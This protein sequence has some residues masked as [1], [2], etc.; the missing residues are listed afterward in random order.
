MI[1]PSFSINYRELYQQSPLF[2][3][4]KLIGVYQE[5]RNKSFT[6]RIFKTHLSVVRK[7][8]RRFEREG[9]EGLRDRSR[10]PKHSPRKTPIHIEA[11]IL[12]ER[13]KTGYGRDR[14][15]RN[16]TARGIPVKPST[17]RYVLR[18]YQVSAKY[19]RSRY[20]KKQRFYDF[21]EL[22]PL[23]HFE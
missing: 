1:D 10:R 17:V 16:L 7:I 20:R 15:A 19:K 4:K 8:I 12:A 13:K 9:E 5:T 22:Y 21:E 11:I 14:I 6:A 23:Q 2:A 3:R 18:R